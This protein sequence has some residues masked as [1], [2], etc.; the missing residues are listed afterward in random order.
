MLFW[1][2]AAKLAAF[3][4]QGRIFFSV[5][6]ERIK[7]PALIFFPVW[8]NVLSCGL[9]GFLAIKIASPA[10]DKSDH[11]RLLE[12]FKDVSR[13]G[14]ASLAPGKLPALYLG[15]EETLKELAEGIEGLKQGSR[16]QELFY[17]PDGQAHL[18]A[19]SSEI[20]LLIR[21]EE[22]LIGGGGMILATEIMEIIS[23]RLLI[24]K[25]LAWIL[26]KDLLE[27]IER[28]STLAG[29]K[30]PGDLSPQ[31]FPRYREM[32]LLLCSLDRLEV[33]GRDSA[34]L[35]AS[36][37]LTGKNALE[38]I[39]KRLEGKGLSE[40]FVKR[41]NPGELKNLSLNLAPC[42]G[43]RGESAGITATFTYKTSSIV[44][45]LGR[46]VRELRETI[47]QDGILAEFA[48]SSARFE[49]TLVHTRW[50]SVGAINDENC[51]PL[52]N[53][54]SLLPEGKDPGDRN[55]RFPRYGTGDWSISAMVNGDIDNYL[56]LKA[57]LE[58]ELVV[59]PEVTTD[60]KIVPLAIEGYLLAGFALKEAFRKAAGD[61]EGSYAIVMKSNLEPHKTYLALRGSGQ[62]LYLGLA[63]DHYIFSSEVYGLVETASV[64]LK[65]NG[66]LTPPEGGSPGQICIV[67]QDSSG[68]LAGIT[69]CHYDGSPAPI[70][71]GSLR[72]T[73]ITTRD[74]DR[75]AYPHYFLKEITEAQGSVQKTLRGKYAI[76][77]D[78]GDKEVRFTLGRDIIPETLELALTSGRI[79]NIFVI[80]HGTAAVAGNVIADAFRRSL[81]QAGI[82]TEGLLA[83]EFSGFFLPGNLEDSLVI[84]VTQSGTTTD[85]NRAVA[86]A[87]ERGGTILAIVNRRQSDITGKA[88]GVFYT[89]DGRDI[90]MSVAS[91]KAFYSQIVAGGILALKI[92]QLLKTLPD[93]QIARELLNLEETPGLLKEILN[94]R[95]EIADS[96]NRLAREKDHWAVLGSG[97]NKHAADEIRIK[98]SELCYMTIAADIVEN[99]KHIDLSTEPLILV[100]AAGS[101]E[102][103]L[104]DVVKDVAIFKAHKASVVVFADAGEERFNG[105]ADTVIPLPRASSFLP[106][107]LNTFAG[108]LWGYFAARAIDEDALFL[109][110]F[111]G[112]LNNLMARQEREGLS[113]NERLEDVRLRQMAKAYN[114]LFQ[115]RKNVGSFSFSQVRTVSDLT[116]LIKYA[117]GKLPLDDFWKEFSAREGVDSPID[118]LDFVLGR[119][120]DELS[121]PIDSIRHQAKTVTVGTSRKEEPFA[122]VIFDLLKELGFS[123][124]DILS[125]NILE[126][127]RLQTTLSA[128]SGYTL[129]EID[130]LDEDGNP[131]AETAITV[132]KKGGTALGMKS[133]TET[134]KTLMGTKRTIVATGRI[135]VGYGAADGKPLV[136]I[137]LHNHRPVIRH[138][139]LLHVTFNENLSLKKKMSL[140]GY[141]YNDIRDLV[142]EYNLP[143]QDDHLNLV[144]LGRLLGEPVEVIAGRIKE[145]LAGSG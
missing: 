53:Y 115:S 24:L 2:K 91:T 7:A 58:K 69:S 71:E 90:E 133:R 84:A 134:S 38:G 63:P 72:K 96:A 3:L 50:A 46:N 88:H 64:F 127:V 112:S 139:L 65:M 132:V 110:E 9:A 54:S 12:L 75:G 37:V 16:Y 120:V 27:N 118:Y 19:L 68:G 105:I 23:R 113:L 21:Q 49:S 20:D 111:R 119:G 70:D 80:G 89:S 141:R 142:N 17:S 93:E 85:T 92:A 44:G 30:N 109:R 125:K 126:A 107:I 124:Q 1:S 87:S 39:K 33:R 76:L 99:K 121:R 45:E 29:G 31:A 4:R 48:S 77:R 86:M 32:N 137:P 103:V 117:A 131:A 61:F 73:E 143:W 47:R 106:V 83:S 94:R 102:S 10:A 95:D 5:T 8:E 28:I 129:Y 15:G 97:P 52:N 116:L 78:K 140:L 74:I 43:E 123:P 82:K 138:L 136:I 62:S 101:P 35:Q 51:H 67:D 130:R 59:S 66:E 108:H 135:H 18:A 11:R 60:S 22:A 25:D 122:G 6:P 128:I 55:K 104:G 36:F 98:L 145:S 114:S 56:E 100:C 13:L 79:R 144:P 40:A 26:K 34:G 41:Q 14:L 42:P 81:G 57:R